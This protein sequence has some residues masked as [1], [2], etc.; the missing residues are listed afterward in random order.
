MK[1]TE[2]A[3][4]LFLFVAS[5][6]CVVGARY[7]RADVPTYA[8]NYLHAAPV[9]TS[10]INL[11]WDAVADAT[12]Y[13]I[14][15]ETPVGGGFTTIVAAH[16]ALAYNDTGLAAGTTYNYRVAA[17]NAS[18]TGP[19]S[20]NATVS[21][22]TLSA[23]IVAAVP[24]APLNLKA[25]GVAG[26]MNLSWTATYSEASITG[27]RIER[28][29]G[30]G[31][32]VLVPNT[33]SA[34]TTYGDS[35]LSLGVTYGY[36]VSALSSAGPSNPS[37]IAYGTVPVPPNEPP[38]AT[39]VAG[40][41]TATVS[42]YPASASAGGVTGY[43]VAIGTSTSPIS[44]GSGATRVTIT[45]LTNGTSYFF[46][47]SGVNAAGQGFAAK[48]NTVTPVAVPVPPPLTAT[49]TLASSPPPAGGPTPTPTP[50]PASPSVQSLQGQL[51]AL[52]AQLQALQFQAQQQ[53][54][55]TPPPS[56]PPG[57]GGPVS[58]P[59]PSTP[60]S[61]GSP[62]VLPSTIF[63][64]DL[65]I[66]SRGADVKAL[67]EFLIGQNKGPL[68]E[69]LGGVGATGYFGSLTQKTLAEYQ[70]SVGI[71]PTAGYFG[72]KTRN[73]INSLTKD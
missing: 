10:Q 71:S 28:D 53:S 21:A 47:V 12:G 26:G 1:R 8:P 35:G 63:S 18:G 33:G 15:R 69:Q 62:T 61:V 25:T 37:Q 38:I 48:T 73:Y 17:V 55:I 27:Y 32:T 11:T 24:S 16:G 31:F 30:G 14:D 54:A 45:G 51:N 22:T 60:P 66:G 7:V 20:N 13:Q 59:S 41:G 2:K 46:S 36:K 64:R 23:S 5:L 6:F 43:V 50:T 67:Q 52:I 4:A 44:V 68:A 49:S 39:A 58:T 65:D 40:D 42:W 3:F 70:G 34:A 9:G 56:A 72:P 19:F 57:G 29:V